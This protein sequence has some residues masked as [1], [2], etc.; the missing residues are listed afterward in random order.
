MRSK[1]AATMTDKFSIKIYH[2]EDFQ[3]SMYNNY[4]LLNRNRSLKHIM[5]NDVSNTDI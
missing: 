1:A 3:L 2:H 4:W 5:P